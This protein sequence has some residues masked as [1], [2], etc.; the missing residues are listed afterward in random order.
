MTKEY[1]KFIKKL[2]MERGISQLEMAKKLG[3]SRPSYIAIE[4]EKRELTLSEAEKLANALGTDLEGIKKGL[5]PNAEKYKEMILAYLRVGSADGK[6]TKTKLAKLL[7]L[8][9]FAWFYDHLQSMSG[10]PYRKIQYGPVPDPY[11]RIIDELFDAG[12][13]KIDQTD[14][15]AMLISETRSAG[16]EQLSHLNADEKNLIKKIGEKWK[17][18]RTQEIVEFTHK[19]LPYMVSNDNEII[20]Y[21]VITQ[22][23]PGYVY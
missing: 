12:K 17:G 18:K 22:E 15:G 3:I 1:I 23:D 2:R 21:E 20:P 16:R 5:A 6:I 4:Q 7:Y 9:D 14:E 10:M 19:Q 8:A 11:F 13:I